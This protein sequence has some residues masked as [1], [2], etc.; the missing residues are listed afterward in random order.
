MKSGGGWGSNDSRRGWRAAASRTCSVLAFV[1]VGLV[2]P[3]AS[4]QPT[5]EMRA[6]AEA[7]FN[8][9]RALIE[10]SELVAACERFEQSQKLDPQIGTLLYL[11]TCHEQTGKTTTAWIEFKE[12]LSLAEAEDKADRVDQA[13]EGVTRVEGSLARASV[14]LTSPAAD[15]KVVINGRALTIF[16]T[17]LPYDPGTL[18]IEAEAPGHQPHT[19]SIELPPG[20]SSITITIPKLAAIAKPPPKPPP[21]P[22]EPD[23]TLA[24]VIGGAGA[25]IALVGLGLG[26]GAWAVAD[27]ADEH[28]E[29][30]FCDTEGLEGHDTA[31]G[32]AWASNILTGAGVLGVGAG[33]ILYFVAPSTSADAPSTA[34]LSAPYF[35]A[36]PGAF[37]VGWRGRWQ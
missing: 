8:E 12:A 4:A 24:F 28:C 33:V 31:D 29:G 30:S 19:Q 32:L 37:E 1:V 26:G 2:A 23:H 34:A 10:Q 6:Q 27:A 16:D 20:P 17:A 21:P 15:Q 14:V 5:P 22:P 35:D 9:G 13:R 25:G 7:L 3:R 18:T 11:A 36:G